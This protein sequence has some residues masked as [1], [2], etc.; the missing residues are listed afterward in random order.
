[1]LYSGESQLG[2][3]VL[4]I[5]VIILLVIIG[6]PVTRY[7]RKELYFRSDEF[8][9]HKDSIQEIVK[10]HNDIL[11]YAKQV[12]DFGKLSFNDNS[13]MQAE[14]GLSKYENTSLHNYVRDRNVHDY[15]NKNVRA[16]SLQ[17][18]KR[19]HEEPIKYLVKYFDIKPTEENLQK[20][21]AVGESIS[22]VENAQKNL[23]ARKASIQKDFNPPKF[24]KKHYSREL[25]E[26]TGVAIQ[27][28]II[29]YPEYIFEYVSSGGNSSQK[30]TIKLNGIVIEAIEKYLAERIKYA[31]SAKAQRA[32]MTNS[33]RQSIKARDN[34]TC[35]SCGLSIDDEEHLLLE[36]DHIVPVS[37][38]GQSVEENLQTLCWQCNRSKSDKMAS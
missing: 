15:S 25:L 23:H 24:I 9:N 14:L 22:R 12:A 33:L 3:S 10:A 37:K 7:I 31:K 38:G 2:E 20:I 17:V 16:S 5:F 11:Q 27:T 4:M 18:V 8:V 34:F 1:M 30:T 35:Q 29:D 21:E 32:L 28:I 6:I 36:V 19:A 26:K 13:Q